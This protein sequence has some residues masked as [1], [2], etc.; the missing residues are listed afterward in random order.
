MFIF[1]TMPSKKTK[2]SQSTC[3]PLLHWGC[4]LYLCCWLVKYSGRSLIGDLI[5][6]STVT[7]LHCRDRGRNDTYTYCIKGLSFLRRGQ[8]THNAHTHTHTL[9]IF[10]IFQ[11]SGAVFNHA[12]LEAVLNF[13]WQINTLP[14]FSS[15][16]SQ[17]LLC[18]PAGPFSVPS[19]CE[20]LLET[21]VCE[22]KL[23][24]R[25]GRHRSVSGGVDY[26][27]NRCYSWWD[28]PGTHVNERIWGGVWCPMSET[29]RKSR[30]ILNE[31]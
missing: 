3:E 17:S 7:A 21:S 2:Q 1:K 4:G 9:I 27:T 15:P 22:M 29:E 26:C 14:I 5:C 6:W 28:R 13:D 12:H 19:W 10:H 20:L 24:L 8:Q 23:L 18:S 30:E 11:L 25:S 31:M 16:R